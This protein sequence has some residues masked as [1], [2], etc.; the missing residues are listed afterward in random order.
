MP[1]LHRSGNT[2]RRLRS[3]SALGIRH[4]IA[5]SLCRRR[6]TGRHVDSAEGS[7]ASERPNS[8]SAG[9]AGRRNTDAGDRSHFI[10]RLC[11]RRYASAGQFLFS[12][13]TFKS[14][15][16]C[17]VDSRPSP[18]SF[19]FSS[20]GHSKDDEQLF[21]DCKYIQYYSRAEQRITRER[22]SSIIWY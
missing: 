11:S 8:S 21:Q 7:W 12:I 16:L 9:T 20:P 19:S 3:A 10:S 6:G 1:S 18:A 14:L 15:T 17:M 2:M 4:C 22:C 5:R 13:C